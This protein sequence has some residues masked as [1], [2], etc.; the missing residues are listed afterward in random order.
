MIPL[1]IVALI[2]DAPGVGPQQPLAG[3]ATD[4]SQCPPTGNDE[5]VV[6]K[7]RPLSERSPRY[8]PSTSGPTTPPGHPLHFRMGNISADGHSL[9]MAPALQG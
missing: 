9:W 5:I 1:L 2:S 8:G 4:T 3:L 6:C 7:A